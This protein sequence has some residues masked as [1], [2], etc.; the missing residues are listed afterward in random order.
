MNKR[1]QNKLSFYSDV[2]PY[3]P[4][5]NRPLYWDDCTRYIVTRGK[6][7]TLSKSVVIHQLSTEIWNRWNNADLCPMAIKILKKRS[8]KLFYLNIKS[9]AKVM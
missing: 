3:N 5:Q 8:R 7:K 9:T 1:S 2:E 4:P 6:D